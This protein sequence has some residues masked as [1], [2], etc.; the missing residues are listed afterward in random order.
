MG[1]ASQTPMP[2]I[3]THVK[4]ESFFFL[5]QPFFSIP[6]SG[7]EH[8]P[9]TEQEIGF[10]DGFCFWINIFIN[11]IL[12]LNYTLLGHIIVMVLIV[13][14]TGCPAIRCALFFCLPI[15]ENISDLS[16]FGHFPNGQDMNFPKYIMILCF[17][18]F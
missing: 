14:H 1:L 7:L 15:S 18:C 10:S 2:K 6:S 12:I 13:Q 9:H 3:A 17:W 4:R 11:R 8:L 5:V 16:I